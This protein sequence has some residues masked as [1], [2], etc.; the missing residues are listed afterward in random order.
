MNIN[1]PDE[2]LPQ[3]IQNLEDAK[4]FLDCYYEDLLDRGSSPP[5]NKTNRIAA[6]IVSLSGIQEML[7]KVM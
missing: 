7:K 5:R 6:V 2:L 4:V 1:I 3:I